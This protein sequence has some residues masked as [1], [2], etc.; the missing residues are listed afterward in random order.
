MN[1]KTKI[2]FNICFTLRAA[3]GQ[4]LLIFELQLWQCILFIEL[5]TDLRINVP[6]RVKFPEA[7]FANH[8]TRLHS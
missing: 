7:A 3:A 2:K 4:A 5:A 6:C 8:K 1:S